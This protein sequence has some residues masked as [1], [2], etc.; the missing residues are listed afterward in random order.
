MIGRMMRGSPIRGTKAPI[1]MQESL[2]S[3]EGRDT[4]AMPRLYGK[5]AIITGATSGMGRRT[6]ERF[7]EEGA[8]VI[9]CGRRAQLGQ[10]PEDLFGAE[11]CHFIRADVSREAD[12]KGL[13]DACVS[14][15]G[16][17]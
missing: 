14:R 4:H 7:V 10:K 9:V 8:R 11:R 3:Q 16:R 2:S 6:A 12:V 17:V 15:W 1:R 13:I 5:T